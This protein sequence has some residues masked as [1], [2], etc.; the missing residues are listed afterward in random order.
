MLRAA[1]GKTVVGETVVGGTVVGGTVVGGAVVT[2]EVTGGAVVT[3]VGGTSDTKKGVGAVVVVS[4]HSTF[5]IYW[6][7]LKPVVA[8]SKDQVLSTPVP[9]TTLVVPETPLNSP[10]WVFS[11]GWKEAEV[12]VIRNVSSAARL[13]VPVMVNVSPTYLSLIASTLIQASSRRKNSLV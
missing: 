11:V 7:G 6:S 3:T 4:T 10:A 9:F 12:T 1:K 2:T 8:T 13:V 5:T